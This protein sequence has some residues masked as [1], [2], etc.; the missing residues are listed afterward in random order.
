MYSVATG[1]FGDVTGLG[2]LSGPARDAFWPALVAWVVVFGM[3]TSFARARRPRG[4]GP[5]AG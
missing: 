2:F 4:A 1:E 5:S 3:L